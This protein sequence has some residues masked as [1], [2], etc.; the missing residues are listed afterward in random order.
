M[1]RKKQV[2]IFSLCALLISGCS[3]DVQ[4]NEQSN[5]HMMNQTSNEQHSMMDG[6]TMGNGHMSHDNVVR[7]KDSTGENEI[8]IPPLL[9]SETT[10]GTEYTVKAQKGSVNILDNVTT[11]TLGYNGD[12]LGP[13]L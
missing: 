8:N 13:V 9:T 3:S 10:V 4:S 6:S 1:S 11:E 5:E 7:L 2:V 12:L